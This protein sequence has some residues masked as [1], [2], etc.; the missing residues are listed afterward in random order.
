M[1]ITDDTDELIH[2]LKIT[3]LQSLC[4]LNTMKQS[5]QKYAY[6]LPSSELDLSLCQARK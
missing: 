3:L 5:F 4:E 6:L 2:F 1:Q